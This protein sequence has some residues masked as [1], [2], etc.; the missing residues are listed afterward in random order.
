MVRIAAT[1][2]WTFCVQTPIQRVYNFFA[3][4]DHLRELLDG[5]DTHVLLGEGHVRWVLKEKVE[6]GIRFKGDYTVIY[7]GNGVDHVHWQCLEG[8]MGNEG[9]VWLTTTADGGTEIHYREIV[10]PDLPITSIMARLVQP[11]VAR[12]LRA[13]LGT[14][15]DRVKAH[16][17]VDHVKP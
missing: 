13:E 5:V 15:L 17:E 12:E 1:G 8:N 16:F 14:F 6:R 3:K 7:Q 11:I 10:A 2:D 4:P 9:D